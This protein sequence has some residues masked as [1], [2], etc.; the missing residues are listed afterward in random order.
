MFG[1][2]FRLL[3]FPLTYSSVNRCKTMVMLGGGVR[4]ASEGGLCS[5]PL[6]FSAHTWP[7]SV[8][9]AIAV[10]WQ[11]WPIRE[12]GKVSQHIGM[13]ITALALGSFWCE[14]YLGVIIHD[15]FLSVCLS[16]CLFLSL[17]L[18]SSLSL[19]LSFYLYAWFCSSVS[20]SFINFPSME[21][22]FS[23]T[24]YCHLEVYQIKDSCLFY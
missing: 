23:L 15:L 14:L 10:Y 3:S 18:S 20:F 2:N 17:S 5:C 21:I 22:I 6:S 12:P 9:P 24:S 8:S 16:L 1:P 11:V 7:R 13:L 4:Q 19:S